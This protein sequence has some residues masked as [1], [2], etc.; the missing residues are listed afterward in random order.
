MSRQFDDALNDCLERIAR[1]EDVMQCARRHSQLESELLPLLRVARATMRVAQSASYRPEAKAQGLG[2]LLHVLSQQ[3]VPKRRRFSF[4]LWRPVARPVVVALAAVVVTLLAAGGTTLA[5]SNSVP[6]EPLYWVKTTKE[7]VSLLLIPRSD[8][9]KAQ[10]QARLAS[11]RGQELRQ[12]IS[13]GRLQQA[14]GLVSRIN[15]HLNES[16]AYARINLPTDPIEMPVELPPPAMTWQTQ[17]FRADLE[18]D[19]TALREGFLKLMEN[20]PPGHR[21]QVQQFMRQSELGYRILIDATYSGGIP[22]RPFWKADPLLPR[23]R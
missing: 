11:V 16:A 23:G 5:S 21:H 1:G 20:V 8:M 17:Q 2:R 19:G 4:P 22:G 18:R 7:S 15:H 9:D 13:R 3:G 10:V 6:G 12:L 14:E